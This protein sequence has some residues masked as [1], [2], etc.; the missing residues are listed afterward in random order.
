MDDH[1]QRFKT[2]L[3]QFLPEF[4]GLFFPTWAARFDF[5]GT[6]WLDQEAFL[7]PP[8]GEKRVLDLVANVPTRQTVPDPAGRGADHTLVVV[9]IE[10]E[11]AERAT[12][13]RPRMLWHYE[14]LRRRHGLPVFPICLFLRLGLNGIGWDAYEERLWEEPVLRFAYAYVGLPALDGMTYFN[15]PN[16]L[17]LALSAL[18]K[19]P[20]AD[21]VRIKA[22]GLDRLARAREDEVRKYLLAECFDNYL[23]L[24]DAERIEFERLQAEQFSEGKAMATGWLERGRVEGRVEGLREAARRML[25]KKFGQLPAGT[26]RRL[27]AIPVERVEE[28]LPAILDANSLDDLGLGDTRPAG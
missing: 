3:R 23:W 20:A 5:A 28:L 11:S 16:V 9:N 13:I 8:Q 18:M 15:S 22:E 26:L 7:D 2:L 25:E 19:L 6:E 21:R 10:I 1:D 14:S 17:G 27:D 4:I 12:D 24:T